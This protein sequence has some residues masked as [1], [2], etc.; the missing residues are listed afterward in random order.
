MGFLLGAGLG[1]SVGSEE[2]KEIK[3]QGDLEKHMEFQINVSSQDAFTCSAPRHFD[4]PPVGSG[5]GFLVGF[6]LG[7][8]VGAAVGSENDL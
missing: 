6:L 7:L 8:G 5:L 1:S 4:V 3:T 2:T